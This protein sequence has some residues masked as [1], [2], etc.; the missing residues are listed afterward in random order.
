MKKLSILL[1][2]LT[3]CSFTSFSQETKIEDESVA[4]KNVITSAYINGIH[5]LGDIQ[6]IKD[7]FHPGFDL[8]IQ[9]K[10]HLSFLPIYTWIEMVE[11]RKTENPNGPAE[12]TSVE[13]VNIDVTGTAAVAKIDLFKGGKKIFTD[14]LSLYKFDES[15][16]IVSK[17][18]YRIPE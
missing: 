1:I 16:K 2:I 6:A 11:Q 5:N 18:Y 17:I 15:W 4:I 8:L 12:K 9:D 14:Y 10:G 3:L 13:F 7:G